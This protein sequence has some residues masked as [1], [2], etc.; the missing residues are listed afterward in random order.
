MNV[1]RQSWTDER[2]DDFQADVGRRF[3]RVDCEIRDIRLEMKAG[4]EQVD[5]RFEK[6]NG[7]FERMH[8]LIITVG[9]GL[10]GT[11]IVGVIVNH[12]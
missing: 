10:I 6:V 8:R 5:K 12:L 4:F 9:G 2:L 7:Q 11:L 1:M 3:D